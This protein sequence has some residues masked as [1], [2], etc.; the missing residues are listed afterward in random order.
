MCAHEIGP[1]GVEEGREGQRETETEA[2]I[3]YFVKTVSDT[4]LIYIPRVNDMKYGAA[5]NL[6]LNIDGNNKYNTN[7]Y[8]YI[9]I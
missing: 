2:F 9:Y 7:I 3:V 5:T 8:I 1:G 4:E 6:R